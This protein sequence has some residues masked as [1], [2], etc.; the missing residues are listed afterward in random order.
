MEEPSLQSRRIATVQ[1]GT[2]LR[3]VNQEGHWIKVS[4]EDSSKIGWIYEDQVE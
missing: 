4:L 2:A 3:K 1:H